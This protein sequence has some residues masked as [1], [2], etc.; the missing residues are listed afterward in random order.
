VVLADT[1]NPTLLNPACTVCHRIMDPVA[2]AFQNYSDD[3]YYKYSWGGVD[4]LDDL[5]KESGEDRAVRADTWESRETLSWPVS[6]AAD[7]RPVFRRPAPSLRLIA[8]AASHARTAKAS[9]IRAP[10]CAS[11]AAKICTAGRGSAV[12]RRP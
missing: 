5:Y 6:L 2:G 11:V 1:N 10:V 8:S 3:G 4:S 9:E 12:A 7:T